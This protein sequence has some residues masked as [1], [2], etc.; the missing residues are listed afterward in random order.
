VQQELAQLVTQPGQGVYTARGDVSDP[1]S[2]A[3]VI[4]QSQ[5][6]LPDTT[7]LVNN[8]GVYGPIGP[9][10]DIDW[11]DWVE[12]I[13]IN[14]F[15]AVL[16]CREIIPLMRARGYGKIINLSGGGATA[17]LPRFS[18]YAASKVAIVR[19]TETFAEE[20]RDAH[21]D[22]NAIAPGA[23]NTRL[24]DEVLAAGPDKA[25]HDFYDRSL[26]QR[27][28]GGAPLEKGA[29]LA[30]FLASPASDG[31]TGRLLSALWDDWAGLPDKGE[32][33][34]KSDIYTLRRI[35]PEDRGLKW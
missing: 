13:Q 26:K 17:P 19:L 31:I 16:M 25:G 34:T 23:L 30:V 8:A 1:A 21:I 29:A 24:L 20:L 18:A 15:G 5:E 10:E 9:I 2:C 28:Q 22:V 32:Q 33:F 14:L 11:D 12:A 4:R 7:I 3:E 27:D 35:V 6:L